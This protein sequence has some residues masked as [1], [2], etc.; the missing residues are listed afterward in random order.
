MCHDPIDKMLLIAHNRDVYEVSIGNGER[1]TIQ[2][3]KIALGETVEQ[4][5]ENVA[6]IPGF[7]DWTMSERSYMAIKENMLLLARYF[8]WTVKGGR[9]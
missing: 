4:A 3:F 9:I 5:N 2:E 8:K 6:E 7:Y 1:P